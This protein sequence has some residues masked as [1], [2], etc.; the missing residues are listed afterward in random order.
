MTSPNGAIPEQWLVGTTYNITWNSSS[1][2]A[3]TPKVKISYSLN[4]GTYLGENDIDAQAPNTGIY[5]WLVPD[6]ITSLGRIEIRDQSDFVAKDES[7]SN[8]EVIS[9]FT[10]SAPNGGAYYEVDDTLE[11]TWSDT[12]STVTD[13]K[14]AYSKDPSNDDPAFWTDFANSVDI[15]QGST[16]G[17]DGSYIWTIPNNI[18]STVRVMVRSDTDNGFDISDEEFRI[19]GKLEITVPTSTDQFDIGTTE[20]IEWTTTGTIEQVD[21]LYDIYDGKGY[22]GIAGNAD[23]YKNLGT[24]GNPNTGD[25]TL[26][27][28]ADD[29]D[30]CTPDTGETTCSYSFA[31]PNVPD[32]PTANARIKI[33]DS[34]ASES[35]VIDES[36]PFGIVGN[37]TIV[38]PN[39]GDD[40]RV[41][42]TCNIR[43]NWGGTIPVVTLYYAA[44][45]DEGNP[46]DWIEIVTKDYSGDGKVQDGD[47][48][49]E[50]RSYPW[51]IPEDIEMSPTA[52]I[53]IVDTNNSWVLDASNDVFSVRGDFLVTSPNGDPDDINDA[54]RWVTYDQQPITWD[55][56]GTI[57]YVYLSYSNDDFVN[58]IH[59]FPCENFVTDETVDVCESDGLDKPTVVAA[60]EATDVFTAAG[61]GLIDADR[62]RIR[63]TTLPAGVLGNIR[64]HV[65]S[66]TNDTFQISLA[67]GGSAVVFTT[68]GADVTVQRVEADVVP[69]AVS[70]ADSQYDWDIPDIVIKEDDVYVTYN[71]IQIRV[72]DANDGEVFGKSDNQFKID[73]YK[74]TWEVF[75]TL[76]NSALTELIVLSVKATDNTVVEWDESGVSTVDG[77]DHW[78]PYGNWVTTWFK[79]G[80][81]DKTQPVDASADQLFRL[82]MDT[83]AVH[84]WRA[85]TDY[86]Y[87]PVTLDDPDEAGDQSL[88]DKLELISYLERDG[89]IMTGAVYLT[90]KFYEGSASYNDGADDIA[91]GV[92]PR[93]FVDGQLDECREDEAIQKIAN[94][95][96]GLIIPGTPWTDTGL[97]AGKVYTILTTA[98][99]GT[100][101]TF[102]TPAAL[103]IS[104]VV[105]LSDME[106]EIAEKLDKPLSQVEAAIAGVIQ[107]KMDTQLGVIQSKM[108]IQTDMIDK[109]LEDFTKSVAGSI[110]SLGDAATLS[111]ASAADLE[112]AAE[113]SELAAA[114]LEKIAKSQAAKLLI[115][116]SVITGE[117]VKLRYRGYSSGLIP[118]IVILDFE[119]VPIVETTPMSEV[120]DKEALYEYVIDEIDSAIY[121]PGTSFTVI[122]TEDTTGSVESGAVYIETAGGQLLM[123]RTVL[124]GDK[125]I[126]Q[127]RGR[128]DWKPV[129]TIVNFEN[130]E[131]IKDSKMIKVKDISGMFEYQIDS[132]QPDMYV[133]GKPVTVTVVEPTTATV[134]SGTFIVESTSLTSLEGL[135]ASGSGVKDV[136]QDALDAINAVRGTLATGGDVSMALERIKLKIN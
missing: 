34:R 26:N 61:H 60:D 4:G 29:Y 44:D 95:E 66:A 72:E 21:I 13:V 51:N 31:W 91:I 92:D 90:I 82:Y 69:M 77:R 102:T 78:T 117:P 58:D 128:E 131:I 38:E 71:A 115:P 46:D 35:D 126:I 107:S 105:K 123:P 53:I 87:T 41:N 130:E 8:F 97:E 125:V 25:E 68:D 118:L 56:H 134:E 2:I 81:E 129:I 24:D 59:Y 18:S 54:E 84:I 57:D 70:N 109:S 93:I 121:E 14:L 40:W 67:L 100:C 27:V 119:N 74:M 108:N 6:K 120:E 96:E 5:T 79:T 64:Y 110:K 10:L 7:D 104:E 73:Y 94:T 16:T 17:N 127:F 88:P 132:V 36:D 114:T 12:G 11:I 112:I 135:V 33:V 37:F 122:V 39:G 113:R 101:G 45:G 76:T 52:K 15:L 19:R 43:W 136:A 89:S 83:T 1:D 22:D 99:I 133:P 98:V 111:L 48:G 28:I 124:I 62:V 55:T 9:D 116:Q 20:T 49:D 23:D 50:E 85:V 75:D 30:N 106:K 63:G 80:Y 65:K 42:S 3:Q 103:S 32:E 86:A 47:N